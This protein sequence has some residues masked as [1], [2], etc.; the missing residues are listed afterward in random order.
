MPKII[1]VNKVKKDFYQEVMNLING[2]IDAKKFIKDNIYYDMVEAIYEK[3]FHRLAD[4]NATIHSYIREA[5]DTYK[6]LDDL[7]QYF[8]LCYKPDM[9]LLTYVAGQYVNY[10]KSR[11]VMQ[12]ETEKTFVGKLHDALPLCQAAPFKR[13]NYLKGQHIRLNDKIYKARI[14]NEELM[15]QTGLDRNFIME[16]RSGR[17]ALTKDIV[18]MLSLAM[19]LSWY[20]FCQLMETL[21]LK[22]GDEEKRDQ[23]LKEILENII[24][25]MNLEIYENMTAVQMSNTYLKE[26]GARPLNSKTTKATE[27]DP[28]RTV[29]ITGGLGFIGRNCI[30]YFQKLNE[31]SNGIKY[32]ICVLTR[33]RLKQQD[34]PEGIICYCGHSD[35]KYVYERILIEN[36]VDYILHLASVSDVE[37]GE[38]N[39]AETF[40]TSYNVNVMCNAILS[41]HIRIQR[42]IFASSQLIY[43]GKINPSEEWKENDDLIIM[44]KMNNY[45]TAKWVTEKE[46][47]TFAKNGLPIAIARLA[48]I[49]GPNDLSS[50]RLIPKTIDLLQK[51]KSPQIYVNSET[52]ESAKKNMLFVDDLAEAF[53]AIMDSS[54][55]KPEIWKSD[56]NN[57]YNIGSPQAVS[58]ETIV[59]LLI[60]LMKKNVEPQHIKK[61]NSFKND[62]LCV[63]KAKNK[64]GFTARTSLKE[65]LKKLLDSI[66]LQKAQS[67]I[68]K[69]ETNS[70]GE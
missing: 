4:E 30:H 22:L 35:N 14:T 56:I 39:P 45:A 15:A 19:R 31:N 34:I 7:N 37:K 47:Q 60:E 18:Y 62:K 58:A 29:L 21:D 54:E 53:H 1:I 48:N 32:R 23:L 57:I 42:L 64:L 63:E 41:N 36:N 33:N 68:R 55:D 46:L 2:S 13:M 51:G 5:V 67:D 40:N 27:P 20:G 11:A 8:E 38:K 59:K 6:K 16:L 26:R 50:N 49:Y 10:F 69:E 9:V 66:S 12:Q 24:Q 17:R 44:E 65:G 3:S 28:V 52:G 70:Q 61:V 25:L 43:S